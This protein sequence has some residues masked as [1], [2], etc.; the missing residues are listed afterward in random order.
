MAKCVECPCCVRWRGKDPLTGKWGRRCWWC[1]KHEQVLSPAD[2]LREVCF[3]S[4]KAGCPVETGAS[5][6]ASKPSASAEGCQGSR[7]AAE[8]PLT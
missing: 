1:L 6:G 2:R 5:V 3:F 4:P 8:T 7:G